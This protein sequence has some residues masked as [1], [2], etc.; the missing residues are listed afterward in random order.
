MYLSRLLI[1]AALLGGLAGCG[2]GP[3][4]D[5]G[6]VGP[7]GPRGEAGPTGPAGSRGPAGRDGA[8]GEK[9]A[10]GGGVRIVRSDCLHGE[11]TLACRDSEIL[12]TA[13]CGP[14]R[15]AATFLAERTASCGVAAN[16]EKGPLVI[17]CASGT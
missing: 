15:R 3:K 10:P 13:Y 1:I 16:T 9:G 17:V 5:Q 6:P 11:C 8:Q 2:E 7:Q 12:V 14:N 4:S